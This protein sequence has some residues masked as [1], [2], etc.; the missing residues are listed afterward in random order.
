[1]KKMKKQLINLLN[2]QAPSGQEHKVVKYVKP[3]LESL[4]DK[5]WLDD[6]RNLLAEKRVGSGKGAT[7]ILSAHMDSVKGLVPGREV[8][9]IDGTFYS[10]KGI[11]GADD[12]AGIAILLAVLRNVEKTCFEGTIKVAFSREE[13]IGCVGSSQIDKEWIEGSDL[14][15][16]VD[17]RGN[18]DIVVGNWS[19]A[20][21]SDEVGTFFEE[22]AAMQDMSWSAVEGGISDACTFA[23]LNVNSVNLSA[24]Y[25]NEHT[26]REYVVL[27][28]M[29]KTVSL[30]L[31]AF[32]LVN[33][34]VDT[35]GDVPAYNRWIQDLDKW[36]RDYSEF[37][38]YDDYNQIWSGEDTFGSVS[39]SVAGDYVN[40]L[41]NYD[42]GS[43]EEVYLS[44]EAFEK[45]IESYE[46][47]VKGE[48]FDEE[49]AVIRVYEET[50][51]S[52]GKDSF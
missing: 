29:K 38:E 11:L 42:D 16:V 10:S 49:K 33:D 25:M 41:Q 3:I 14:A 47:R 30:I 45:I 50:V 21:C 51:E 4:C 12:R 44:Q 48:R 6:Y 8:K 17:R 40:I 34:F 31:Q 24:G 36:Y 28:D 22:C 18:N 23:E 43:R 46:R 52:T 32:A 39:A 13:E 26:P 9:E 15:I 35:F 20:F 5:V 27:E 1:M 2:I 7:I 37:D 19:Q